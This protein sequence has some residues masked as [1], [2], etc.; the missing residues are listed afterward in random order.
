MDALFYI[1]AQFAGAIAGVGFASIVLGAW[2]S[3]PI[4]D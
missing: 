2:L 3:H 4:V 1:A